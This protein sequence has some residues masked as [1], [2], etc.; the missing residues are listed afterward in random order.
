MSYLIR[1]HL[2]KGS[3]FMKW[4]VK[5]QDDKTV[6]YYDPDAV[7]LCLENVVLC[8]QSGTAKKINKGANKTVCAWMRCNSVKIMSVY[9][10]EIS[11]NLKLR[12]NPRIAP[13]WRDVHGDDIDKTTYEGVL[14]IGR[15]IYIIS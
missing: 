6:S 7:S 14:T 12:Y 13:Y 15:S 2:A 9:S 1:F 8:N 5:N 11:D 10:D 3:N 4:Q